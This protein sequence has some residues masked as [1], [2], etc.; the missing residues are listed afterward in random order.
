MFVVVC[1]NCGMSS[2]ESVEEVKGT[3]AVEHRARDHFAGI[4]KVGV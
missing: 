4:I 1:S 2:L 3:V